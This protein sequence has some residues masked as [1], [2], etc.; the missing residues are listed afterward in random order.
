MENPASGGTPSPRSPCRQ[1]LLSTNTSPTQGTSTQHNMYA[2][3][4]HLESP[5]SK[6]SSTDTSK[7]VPAKFSSVLQSLTSKLEPSPSA[8][9]LTNFNF[10]SNLLQTHGRRTSA[11]MCGRGRRGIHTYRTMHPCGVGAAGKTQ[12]GFRTLQGLWHVGEAQRHS[13]SS[14]SKAKRSPSQTNPPYLISDAKLSPRTKTPLLE[15]L[16]IHTISLSRNQ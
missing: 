5:G 10:N 1:S 6:S 16:S 3:R 4:A 12:V 11:H 8:F 13:C 14:I 9:I 15:S 2:H 7:Y